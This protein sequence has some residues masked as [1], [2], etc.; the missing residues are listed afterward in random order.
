V[1]L[2]NRL[3]I[4]AAGAVVAVYGTALM[5]RGIFQYHNSY[6]MTVFSPAV[7]ATGVL[8]FGIGLVPVAWLEKIFGSKKR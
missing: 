1:N 8:I 3:K 7:I 6:S 4:L 2:R 5:W